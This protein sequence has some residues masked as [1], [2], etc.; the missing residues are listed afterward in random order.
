MMQQF[1]AIYQ[2][3]IDL[4]LFHPQQKNI[5]YLTGLRLDYARLTNTKKLSYS[6]WVQYL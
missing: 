5:S 1:I 4:L 3:R 2:L 6:K